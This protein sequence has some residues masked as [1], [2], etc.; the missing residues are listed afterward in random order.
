MREVI[1]RKISYR[2]KI[3]LCRGLNESIRISTCQKD[4]CRLLRTLASSIPR[5]FYCQKDNGRSDAGP[6]FGQDGREKH[7]FPHPHRFLS[8]KTTSCE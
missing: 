4:V 6:I 5:Q 3:R 1:Q 7:A 2:L 8:V